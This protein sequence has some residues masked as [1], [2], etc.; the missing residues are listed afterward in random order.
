M[1]T[2]DIIGALH[3]DVRDALKDEDWTDAEITEWLIG[4]N[5]Q[6]RRDAL[7][8]EPSDA[9]CIAILNAVTVPLNEPP[10]DGQWVPASIERCREAIMTARQE[11]HR[12]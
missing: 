9:E 12:D 11:S 6:V 3:P 8:E 1:S 4:H 7:Q 10:K 5:A 2:H